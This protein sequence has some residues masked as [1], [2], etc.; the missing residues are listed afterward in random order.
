[1]GDVRLESAALDQLTVQQLMRGAVRDGAASAR[2]RLELLAGA[3]A[4][5]PEPRIA[6]ELSDALH[7]AAQ[8]NIGAGDLAAARRYAAQRHDLP[9][10]RDEDHF[11]VNWLLVR[12]ALAGDLDE[13]VA[14]GERLRTGWDRAG[15]PRLRAFAAAPAAAAMVA[16][17][18]GDDAA[19]REWIDVYFQMAQDEVPAYKTAYRPL[20]D[21]ITALHR[22]RADAALA[23]VTDDPETLMAWHTA[24]WRPWYAAL[25]AEAAVLADRDDVPDRLERAR[26]L[27][28]QNPLAAA[29][30]DRSAALADGEPQR[31]VAIAEVFTA[32]CP[33]Q[34]ARTLVLA[35]GASADGGRQIMADLHAAPM[36]EPDR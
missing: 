2:R 19:E 31:L 5:I 6:F 26:A 14:L 28:S 18:R 36:A 12:A 13:A 29:I 10:H 33:Y 15:R 8:A 3:R 9:F 4:G 34:R 27:A 16:G 23:A 1:V 17:L 22:G 32:E 24:S 11:V 25:W 7:M 30:V 21:A 35:G 20:F